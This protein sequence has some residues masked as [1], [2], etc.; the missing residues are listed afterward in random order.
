MKI[1]VL[2]SKGVQRANPKGP[3]LVLLRKCGLDL[4]DRRG[5]KGGLEWRGWLCSSQASFQDF[6]VGSLTTQK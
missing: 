6:L 3:E 2:T 5:M 4:F 1:L